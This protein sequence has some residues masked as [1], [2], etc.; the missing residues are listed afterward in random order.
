[1]RARVVPGVILV[2]LVLAA[3]GGG[4]DADDATAGGGPQ[5]QGPPPAVAEPAGAVRHEGTDADFYDPPDPLPDGRPGDLLRYQEL[6]AVGG[7]TG[8]KILYLSESVA[9]EAIAVSGLAAV[10]DDASTDRPVLSWAHGTTGLADACAPSKE[11]VQGTVELLL[12]GYLD[13]GWVVTATDYEGLGTP[14]LHPYL[15]GISEG[16]AVLD[17]IRA[18]QQLPD[19]RAGTEAVVWG[20]SQGGH[21][22]LFA[23]ELAAEWAPELQVRGVVAGAPP[24]ELPVLAGAL[25]GGAYQGYLAM[26]AGGLHAAYP[27]T[28]LDVVFREETVEALDLLDE[29]CTADVFAEFNAIPAEDFFAGN[30]LDDPTWKRVLEANDPGHRRSEIP[31]L[32]VH[33]EADEQI[34]VALSAV[35]FD[36]LCGLGQVV[37]RRTYPGQG[38]GEVVFAAF[39]ELSTWM[40]D[41]LAGEP[42]RSTCPA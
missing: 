33:G 40:A 28:D 17:A 20:H 26:V 29:A 10:P 38:H 22:A 34:P 25:R 11:T 37:E 5:R 13:R 39:A 32:I 36:R 7:G 16:R 14:G 3:C 8:Y 35:L 30:P 15:A 1:M 31:L 21:A 12:T 27:E 41:R 6:G 18:A 2:A 23:G 42:A 19:A 4:G 9:G 24:S